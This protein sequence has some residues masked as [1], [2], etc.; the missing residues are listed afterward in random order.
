M[1]TIIYYENSIFTNLVYK[2]DKYEK[3]EDEQQIQYC[4]DKNK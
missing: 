2:F 1:V 3:K 4:F